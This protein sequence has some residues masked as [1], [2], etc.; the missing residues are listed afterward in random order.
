MLWGRCWRVGARLRGLRGGLQAP[1]ESGRRG[2][3]SCIDRSGS[4]AA[5][6]LTSAKRRGDH[7]VLSGSKAFISGGGEA[8]I[9]VVMCRT[10]GP[11]PKGISCIVVEKGTPG[12]S[13]GKKERKV[14]WNSQPTRAVIFEDCAVPVANRIGDEGQGFLIAMR[15]LNGGRINVASCSLGAAYAS[16]IL[17]RDHLKV[18][19]QFGEPLASNQY[20]QFKLA[21]MV[22][23]LVASRLMIRHAAVAL[24]EGREDAV[25]LCSMAK[26]FATDE[27]FAICNQA[28]QMHGGYGYLKDCAVQQYMRD[29]RV[30]QILEG[31]NE[32]MRILISRS[33][34]QE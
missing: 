9:Y 33:L 12:L 24:Q 29:S 22:A 11:G 25:A 13:F 2:V 26:L 14:G 10:G 17:T 1:A 31:S 3:V 34:L 21:D 15:G 7:Y 32:V 27:C 18:R 5:S 23:R 28:L 6:L 4:D 19:K 20:L 16:V 8:D 30:H